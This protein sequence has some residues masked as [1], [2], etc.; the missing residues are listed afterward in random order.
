M[1]TKEPGS[2]SISPDTKEEAVLALEERCPH[3]AL[4][5]FLNAWHDR[6]PDSTTQ[7]AVL[8]LIEVLGD[9][10]DGIPLEKGRLNA[11]EA[12]AIRVRDDLYEIVSGKYKLE[13]KR[14]VPSTS[15]R[16]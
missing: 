14:Q 10:V 3:C 5:Q 2:R 7:E 12:V 4:S 8:G 1:T 9:A 11:I 13:Q 15:G 16:H 6:W